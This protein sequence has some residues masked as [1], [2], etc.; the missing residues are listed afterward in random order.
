MGQKVKL[1]DREYDVEHLSG[2]AKDALQSFKFTNRRL[3]EL[4]NMRAILQRAKNSYLES[5]KKEVISDKAGLLI[6]DD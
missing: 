3:R 6:G 4:E 5:L 2:S 1:D